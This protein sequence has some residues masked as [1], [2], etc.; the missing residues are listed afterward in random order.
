MAG[1]DEVEE[2]LSTLTVAS[3]TRSSYRAILR[4]FLK[5][6]REHGYFTLGTAARY[7]EANLRRRE[8]VSAGTAKSYARTVRAFCRWLSDEKKLS[9]LDISNVRIKNGQLPACFRKR[10]DDRDLAYICSVLRRR[11][12]AGHREALML[13]LGVTCSL[14]PDQIA[15]IMFEDLLMTE[16][17]AWLTV[18]FPEGG[19][20]EVELPRCARDLM[21]MYLRDRSFH[22][23]ALPLVAVAS[24]RKGGRAMSPG[25]VRKCLSRALSYLGYDYCDVFPGDPVRI[26]ANC[27]GD[28]SEG[29]R[30]RLA[31]FTTSL[32]YRNLSIDPAVGFQC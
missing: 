16:D 7:Y 21:L 14:S 11:G 9:S 31:S 25:E 4:S 23:P 26:V 32:C 19:S 27:I 18:A 10:I 15:A 12:S 29:D 28:L 6:S 24:T 2:Y 1:T 3:S 20:G 30:A 8:D 13:L 17:G 5:W 22:D